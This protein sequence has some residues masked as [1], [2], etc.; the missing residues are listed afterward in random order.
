MWNAEDQQTDLQ[1]ILNRAEGG[2]G[3]LNTERLVHLQQQQ[4][5]Q[6]SDLNAIMALEMAERSRMSQHLMAQQMQQKVKVKCENCHVLLEVSVPPNHPSETMI[7]RCGNCSSL[8]EVVLRPQEADPGNYESLLNQH[9]RRYREQGGQMMPVSFDSMRRE[10]VTYEDQLARASQL[11]ML[12]QYAEQQNSEEQGRSRRKRKKDPSKPKKLSKYNEF[13]SA[14]VKRL[15]QC[16][17]N[18]D[19]KEMFK[20]A[21]AN[22]KHAK[23]N[24]AN[25]GKFSSDAGPSDTMSTLGHADLAAHLAASRGEKLLELTLDCSSPE[26]DVKVSFEFDLSRGHGEH[27]NQNDKGAS[28]IT[29]EEP[30]D[31]D[32]TDAV[33][34]D[35]EDLLAERYYM[36]PCNLVPRPPM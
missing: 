4:Q 24:P 20:I 1:R 5:A 9:L 31:K 23:E 19:N 17:E 27:R 6:Q 2:E 21:A 34:P 18:Y 26:D 35:K 28:N 14:E 15:K 29:S 13:V 30:G 8:L 7:V 10:D 11:A 32:N 33:L 22:W 16:S 36:D 3:G 12:K 25:A